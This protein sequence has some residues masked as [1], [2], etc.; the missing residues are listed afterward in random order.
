MLKVP[1]SNF[2]TQDS[3]YLSFLISENP[4]TMS[5]CASDL[6]KLRAALPGWKVIEARGR[7][8]LISPE[9]GQATHP[10]TAPATDPDSAPATISASDP[11]PFPF[12]GRKFQ[13]VKEVKEWAKTVRKNKRGKQ[14]KLE[15]KEGNIIPKPRVKKVKQQENML[16]TILRKNHAMEVKKV[17][18]IKDKV[19]NEK[20]QVNSEASATFSWAVNCDNCEYE[21][22]NIKDLK[23]HKTKK[24]NTTKEGA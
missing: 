14:V 5:D 15:Q 7:T 16:R 24:H 11:D 8:L 2:T 18:D 22:T 20:E 19:V 21:A 10:D 1:R 3:L 17:E 9:V 4:V 13:S 6:A 12:Q 23:D